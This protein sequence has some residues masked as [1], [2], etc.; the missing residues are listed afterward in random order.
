MKKLILVCICFVLASTGAYS[1]SMMKNIVN[2]LSFGLKGGVNYSDFTDA[3]FE[4]EGLV[5]FH[6]GAIVN[7][8]ISEGFSVQQE[9]LFST[10]G[11][12][13]TNSN[14]GGQDIKL[15]YASVPVLLKYKTKF[16][17]YVEAGTQVGFRVKEDLEGLNGNNF[18]K[19]L[20][21]GAV[22]GI[23]F[24][25]KSGFGI[26]A[27]Y[28]AGLQKVGDFKLGNISPDLKNNVAQASLFYMF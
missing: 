25:T 11:A 19:K 26:G 6:A 9:F 17:L 10:Q 14:F 24:Q 1:Q 7:F 23:G 5:G 2:R 4:T 12:K 3:N 22:G 28:I 21:I 27:R 13:T 16:G 8:R 20:D 18:A 15:Y